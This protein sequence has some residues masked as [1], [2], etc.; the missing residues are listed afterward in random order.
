MTSRDV[1]CLAATPDENPACYAIWEALIKKLAV[2]FQFFYK[3]LRVYFADGSKP[4]PYLFPD[5]CIG[6]FHF[7]GVELGNLFRFVPADEFASLIFPKQNFYEE[8]VSQTFLTNA[9][10][11]QC[12]VFPVYH[13]THQEV[14]TPGY[15]YKILKLS[16]DLLSVNF[17]ADDAAF[18]PAIRMLNFS[19]ALLYAVCLLESAYIDI[20]G[21]HREPL[22]MIRKIEHNWR[23][24]SGRIARGLNSF[25]LYILSFLT[26]ITHVSGYGLAASLFRLKNGAHSYN[27]GH[28][29]WQI[30]NDIDHLPFKLF[31]EKQI[32]L[33]VEHWCKNIS[34]E[35]RQQIKLA[36]CLGEL[37]GLGYETA[38]EISKAAYKN[39]PVNFRPDFA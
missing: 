30:G 35:N 36:V 10:Y 37:F 31:L 20:F 7:S 11:D 34:P 38:P 24:G 12:P 28:G 25:H 23:L 15:F 39:A 6:D 27:P 4:A 19:L 29:T 33:L 5:G 26:R 2:Q 14:F 13:P 32:R 22:A 8:S 3:S 1:K 18:K 16:P 9:L 17:K 21:K